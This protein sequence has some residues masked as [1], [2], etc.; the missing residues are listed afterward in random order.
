MKKTFTLGLTAFLSFNAFAQ[1][2]EGQ[3]FCDENK[4]GSY[5]PL[6]L[7]EK[8]I[9]WSN[10]R[11]TETRSGT[12]MLNGQ[13]YIAFLQTWEGHAPDT[14]YLREEK[15]VVYQYETCCLEETVRFDDKF[16]KGQTWKT[17]DGLGEYTILSFKGTL[18]T[19]ICEYKNLL[20]IEAKLQSG[21][22]KFYYLKGHGYVGATVDDK[23]ISCVTPTFE[24]D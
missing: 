14:L 1:L 4:D 21:N 16:K 17:A 11:Y 24:F 8:K 5:F 23:I 9:L 18:K 13:E 19:P 3:N 22:F 15:G 10:T 20:V 2:K 7:Q 12:K 6:V